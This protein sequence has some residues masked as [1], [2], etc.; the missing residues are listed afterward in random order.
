M[1]EVDYFK[2]ENFLYFD[3]LVLSIC[4]ICVCMLIVG[5]VCCDC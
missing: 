4:D 2:K 3:E 5:M 1:L